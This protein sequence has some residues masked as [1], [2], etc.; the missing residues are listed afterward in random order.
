MKY[1]YY[2]VIHSEDMASIPYLYY[3]R[4]SV[5][6]IAV[7]IWR[8]LICIINGSATIKAAM[9]ALLAVVLS[10]AILISSPLLAWQDMETLKSNSGPD[11]FYENVK[12]YYVPR[13]YIKKS[14]YCSRRK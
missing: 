3:W 2:R 10:P 5:I 8:D 1:A 14:D 12:L 13:K 6:L 7:N 4:S 9:M 11:F